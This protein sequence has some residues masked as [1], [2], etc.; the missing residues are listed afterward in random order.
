MGAGSGANLG[1]TISLLKLVNKIFIH[2]PIGLE[3][4]MTLAFTKKGVKLLGISKRS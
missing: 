2:K 4:S 3:A 1:S